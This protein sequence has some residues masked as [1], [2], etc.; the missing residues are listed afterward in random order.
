M[1]DTHILIALSFWTRIKGLLG[2]SRQEME[3]SIL[4]M[5]PCK[6]IHTFGMRYSIDV[7]FVDKNGLVLKVK[8]DLP[9]SKTLSCPHSFMVLERAC[10]ADRPWFTCGDIVSLRLKLSPE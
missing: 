7:A 3:D 9:R 4:V 6:S 2:T 10:A 8:R 1:T 5:A